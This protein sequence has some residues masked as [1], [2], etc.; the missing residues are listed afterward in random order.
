MD[1]PSD[2][3]SV[4][5]D[6]TPAWIV[7][8]GSGSEEVD[9]QSG[10]RAILEDDGG[11]R[12]SYAP[13]VSTLRLYAGWLLGWYLLLY[14]LGSYQALRSLPLRLSL[15][16]DFLSSSLLAE[17]SLAVFLFLLLTSLHKTIKGGAILGILFCAIGVILLGLFTVN[18][19]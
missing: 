7:T 17:I 16:D 10:L 3:S 8:D 12:L 15:L 4:S 18:M 13:L 6:G 1:L 11:K 5:T 9:G 19:G 2:S 14:A